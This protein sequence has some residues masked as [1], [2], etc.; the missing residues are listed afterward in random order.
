MPETYLQRRAARLAFEAL[1]REIVFGIVISTMLLAV[2][3]WRYFIVVGANDTLWKGIAICGAL[4]LIAAVVF[5]ALWKG[6][7]Q[8]L[9][10]VMRKLGGF[11]LGALLALV[12]VLLIAPVGWLVR[13]MKGLDPIYAWNGA[14]PAGMEGW[15]GKEVLYETN[16]GQAGK[17]NLLRR[18][19]GVLRFFADRGHYVFLP[20]LI[21]L[22]AL[23][24]VLFFVQTSALAPFIYTLF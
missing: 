11:L 1:K 6:P 9:A 10:A 20:V 8:L 7:E 4:G 22:I 5:P 12:Y 19:L 24:L 18:L 23:G 17:P 21:L 2:G 14:A 15:H 3:A 16:L 13:R